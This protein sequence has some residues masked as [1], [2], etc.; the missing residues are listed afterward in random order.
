MIMHVLEGSVL[1][2]LAGR[3]DRI[4]RA[5]DCAAEG[6]DVTRHWMENVG[7]DTLKYIAVDATK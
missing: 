7:T 4:L 6:E 1:S 2:H 5:G 3:P